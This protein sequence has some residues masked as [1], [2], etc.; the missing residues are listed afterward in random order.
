MRNNNDKAGIE[1]K[2]KTSKTLSEIKKC[3]TIKEGYKYLLRAFIYIN[4]I[5]RFDT[6]FLHCMISATLM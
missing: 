4:S 2:K 5:N 3:L 6:V 1:K